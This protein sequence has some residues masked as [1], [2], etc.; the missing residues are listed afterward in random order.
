M[1]Y[2]LTGMVRKGDDLYLYYKATDSTHGAIAAASAS[3]P[4]VPTTIRRAVVPLHRFVAAATSWVGGS[5]VT[6]PLRF[7]G[8]RLELN[9]NTSGM[10]IAWV[11][12]LGQNGQALKGFSAAECDPIH[13]NFL[14]HTVSWKEK[15]DLTSLAG[16]PVRL[17]F[18]SRATDLYA[19]QFS[20]S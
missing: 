12:I 17:R 7:S 1:V 19:F 15:K 3:K 11:E 6:P 9:I 16:K 5:W 18:I 8:S 14:R 20:R 10:G 13:G 2:L 4:Y